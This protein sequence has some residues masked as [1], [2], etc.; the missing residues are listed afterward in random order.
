MFY[1]GD[2]MMGVKRTNRSAALRTL[3]ERGNISRKRLAESIRLTPAAITKIVGEM[4]AEGLLAEGNTIPGDGVGRRE[5][6]VELKTRSKCALGVLIHPDKAVLCAVWLDGSVIFSEEIPLTIPAPAEATVKALSEKLM[7][8]AEKNKLPRSIVVGLGLAVRGMVDKDGR[9]LI[10]SYGTLDTENFDICDKFEEYTGFPT[11]LANNVQALFGAHLF[12]SRDRGVQS[13]FFLR[14]EHGIVAALSINDRIINGSFQK[15]AEIGHIPVVRRGGKPCICGKCGCLETV[16]SPNAIC[17]DMLEV[18]SEEKTPILF[19]KYKGQKPDE[20]SLDSV[21]DAARY[22]GN[23]ATETVDNAIAALASALK[24]VIYT[25]DPGKIV[26]YGKIFE[27]S[28]YLTKFLAEMGEGV[29]SNHA[30]SIE[31]SQFNCQLD[32]SAA[33]I[34]AVDEFFKRGGTMPD[35]I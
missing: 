23:I 10:D 24:H 33:A 18:F 28:Y 1:E 12:L 35:I 7:A 19:K 21:L 31:K 34:L 8:L 17:R 13:Q 15:C 20:L 30:V 27:D 6:M 5:V 22:G 14:C 2:N 26:L 3:H 16:A 29:D 32:K 25:I 9:V 11:V 4:I